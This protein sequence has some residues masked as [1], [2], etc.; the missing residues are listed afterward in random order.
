MK[1]II[2]EDQVNLLNEGTN[3]SVKLLKK[4]YDIEDDGSSYRGSN[5]IQTFV[6][7]D[8]KDYDNELTPVSVM[9]T[10]NWEIG[11]D[12]ELIFKFMTMPNP[13]TIP[14]ME[15]IGNMDDLN[16]YIEDVHREE[17]ERYVQRLIHRRNNP[18]NESVDKKKKFLI[19]HMGQDFN[20]KIKEIKDTYDVPMSF[21]EGIGHKLVNLW[22]DHWGPMYLVNINGKKYLYQDR[23]DF[24][25]FYDEDGF[26]YVDDEILEELGIDVLGLRF[27]DIIDM[28][29]NEGEPLNEENDMSGE[30][31]EKTK[32]KNLLKKVLENKE[33]VYSFEDKW[34]DLD[35]Y[36]ETYTIE[37]HI[38]VEENIR[39]SGSG[40]V[41][42]VAVIIDDVILDGESV[43]DGWVE[44]GYSENVWYIDKLHDNLNDEFFNLFPF[45][46]YPTF[47]GH[48]EKR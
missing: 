45:S 25:I 39:G 40:T 15:Y 32:I 8:P 28:F 23:G 35:G 22:L 42:G 17:A 13:R 11:Y 10:C 38:E 37:Y 9:S 14:L 1:I 18:L 31:K 16:Q 7:I 21:D 48:D 34:E 29:Y 5:Q 26:D 46:I 3:K 44:I 41:A 6:T 43:Y 30:S 27:K 36:I 24:E 20:G 33:F 47:Y 19:N 4:Y 2:T 12:N